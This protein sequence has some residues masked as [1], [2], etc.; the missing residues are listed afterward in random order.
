M[1]C[2]L[3]PANR[4]AA[5]A[6]ILSQLAALRAGDFDARELDAAKRSIQNAYLQ[7]EDSPLAL[8]NFY[9]GRALMGV[10][11]TAEACCKRFDAVSREDVIRAANAL[12]LDTVYFLNGTLTGEGA[13][14]LAENGEYD[15]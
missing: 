12:T 5:E 14:D 1:H 8:E 3:D 10:D 13:D 6:E 11:C 7:L 9:F 4:D 15:D 2:G